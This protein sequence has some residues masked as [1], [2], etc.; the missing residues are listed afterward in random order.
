[1]DKQTPSFTTQRLKK[2]HQINLRSKVEIT[3]TCLLGVPTNVFKIVLDLKCPLSCYYINRVEFLNI[4]EHA[5]IGGDL[6]LC[7]PGP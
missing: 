5:N 7:S 2:Y 6:N 1:M 3:V 4:L